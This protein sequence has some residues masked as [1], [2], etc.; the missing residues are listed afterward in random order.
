MQPHLQVPISFQQ[1]HHILSG[2]K[3]PA[4]KQVR[5]QTA[6][7]LLFA[8]Y[9]H[10][11]PATHSVAGGIRAAFCQLDGALPQGIA[12][13]QSLTILILMSGMTVQSN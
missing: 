5:G 8:A 13:V 4:C 1:K 12:R 3:V 6:V 2:S 11:K 7:Q 10:N 9:I